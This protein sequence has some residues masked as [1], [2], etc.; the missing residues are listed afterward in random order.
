M[1]LA[2]FF[3]AWR[4]WI[5]WGL[6]GSIS[7]LLR[8]IFMNNGFSNVKT[9]YKVHW[10]GLDVNWYDGEC[11]QLSQHCWYSSLWW[12]SPK[13][14][15]RHSSLSSQWPIM[16]ECVRRDWAIPSSSWPFVVVLPISCSC[17]P[18]FD[19][20]L[21]M[22]LQQ[23]LRTYIAIPIPFDSFSFSTS[24]NDNPSIIRN[25]AHKTSNKF[26]VFERNVTYLT[27]ADKTTKPVLSVTSSYDKP[28]KEA[29][30]VAGDKDIS[31][32]VDKEEKAK[33][34]SQPKTSLCPRC[35]QDEFYG[36]CAYSSYGHMFKKWSD[37]SR[38]GRCVV[39]RHRNAVHVFDWIICAAR[40]FHGAEGAAA[41]L[42]LWISAYKYYCC[43]SCSS[44]RMLR[45]LWFNDQFTNVVHACFSSSSCGRYVVPHVHLRSAVCAHVSTF[46][47]KLPLILLIS[48]HNSNGA[49]LNTLCILSPPSRSCVSFISN[50]SSHTWA[51]VTDNKLRLLIREES[52]LT[53]RCDALDTTIR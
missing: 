23:A 10:M 27:M 52:C 8:C 17:L 16:A 25:F 34:M 6:H 22:T 35:G 26:T 24:L 51:G 49:G 45:V 36:S 30:G 40:G 18:I 47:D 38:L 53:L 28:I 31:M 7:A 50:N 15:V 14:A 9:N 11:Q 2:F 43:S 3:W 19:S 46:I 32:K 12:H 20:R 48:K 42:R 41:C 39:C 33:E 21:H 13:W 1:G 5:C 44:S 29:K 37:G 4:W